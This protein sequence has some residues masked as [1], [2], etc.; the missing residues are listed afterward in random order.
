MP[1]GQ[2]KLMFSMRRGVQPAFRIRT[3]FAKESP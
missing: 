2:G 3:T 1:L